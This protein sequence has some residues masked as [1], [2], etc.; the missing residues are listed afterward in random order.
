MEEKNMMLT[1]IYDK[2]RWGKGEWNQEPDRVD[3][4]HAGFSCFILRN[5]MG[6]WCGYVGVPSNHSCYEKQC[7]DVLVEIHGGLTYAE[8]CSPPICHIPKEG[9]PEDVW[10]LGFDTAHSGDLFPTSII[11]LFNDVVYRNQEYVINETKSLAEQLKKLYD[12]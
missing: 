8:K 10:W 3:F 7:D 5:V 9:M 1:P 6:N 2:S 11:N 4:I 12:Y